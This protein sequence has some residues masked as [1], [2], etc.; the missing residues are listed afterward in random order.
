MSFLS[1]V[2][3]LILIFCSVHIIISVITKNMLSFGGW[4]TALLLEISYILK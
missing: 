3:I 1:V 2:E 4:V